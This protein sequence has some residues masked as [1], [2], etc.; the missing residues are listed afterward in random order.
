MLGI[1]LGLGIELLLGQSPV[2]RVMDKARFRVS[3]RARF[4]FR[5]SIK[6]M[7]RF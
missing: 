1:G 2:V 4:R 3:D 6:V 7:V 5:V